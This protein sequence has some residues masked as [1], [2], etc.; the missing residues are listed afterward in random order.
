MPRVSYPRVLY[1]PLIIHTA[2]SYPGKAAEKAAYAALPPE[3]QQMVS[4]L[5]EN[6]EA[7][8]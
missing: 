3:S 2:A 8:V 7:P 6:T 4:A 1:G 5:V